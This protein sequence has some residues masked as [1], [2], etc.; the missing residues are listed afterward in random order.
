MVKS[1][2]E[3]SLLPFHVWKFVVGSGVEKCPVENVAASTAKD[4]RAAWSMLVGWRRLSLG[5][6]VLW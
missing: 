4:W 1:K 3:T 2:M 5:R 6:S